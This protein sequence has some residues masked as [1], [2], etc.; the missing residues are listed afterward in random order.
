M[1]YAELVLACIFQIRN[2]SSTASLTYIKKKQ[3]NSMSVSRPVQLMNM[4]TLK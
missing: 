3:K 2:N 4:H 1:R